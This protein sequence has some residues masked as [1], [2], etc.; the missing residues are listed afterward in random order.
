VNA[1]RPP[2]LTDRR[3]VLGAKALLADYARLRAD[4]AVLL[5]YDR[6][7]AAVCRDV[8]SVANGTGIAATQLPATAEWTRIATKLNNDCAAVLFLESDESHHT[9]SL[10]HHLSTA[11]DPPRA[12]RLFGATPETL[13]QGFRR[14]QST[15]RRRNWDLI[16]HARRAGCL[17][18]ESERGTRLNVGLDRSASWTST[19]GEF[20][21]GFPGI[22]PPAEVNTRS[23]DVDGIVVV[24]GAIGSNIGWPLDVRLVTNPVT[25]RIAGGRISDVDCSHR[26]VRDLVE[27]FLRVPDC[28]EVVE[29][30]IG[31]NDGISGFVP[32]DVLLNERVAS[33]HLGVGSADAERAEQ[34]LHLDFI[35][36]RC[37]ILMGNYVA[38]SNGRF[39]RPTIT[40]I[41]DRHTYDVPV[42]LHDAL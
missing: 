5:V 14:R 27:E 32:S 34:N 41:P 17:S 31:T 26:L 1:G 10:L 18:V 20:A 2:L 24:D 39:A 29:I 8:A 4:D 21:D 37:R 12:Y 22:L 33:F 15:L 36:G 28:N 3:F 11:P 38:L 42:R 25:L 23:A 9:H 7:V 40:A 6:A 30:G 19:C 13:R 16:E 35:L